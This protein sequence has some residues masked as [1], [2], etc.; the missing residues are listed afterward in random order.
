MTK[1]PGVLSGMGTPVC[2]FILETSLPSEE[3]RASSSKISYTESG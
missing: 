1:H 3:V 2:Q